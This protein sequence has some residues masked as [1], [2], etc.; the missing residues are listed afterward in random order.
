MVINNIRGIAFDLDGT[1]IDSLP[2]IALATSATLEHLGFQSCSLEQ[3]KTWIGNGA[4]ILISR[5]LKFASGREYSGQE[6]NQVMPIFLGFYQDFLTHSSCCFPK[7]TS[8]L[9]RLSQS[10]LKLGVITNK[11]HKFVAPLLNKL[12]IADYFSAVL[13]GDALVEMK[14]SPLPL[15]HVMQAW[16]LNANEFLMVGDSK[17]DISAAKAAN[18]ASIGLTY[19][20]NYGED[21]ALSYPTFVCDCF[22][23]IPSCLGLS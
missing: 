13:G 6:L 8:T 18:C 7:V 15:Q 10:G 3:V 19:G 17:N 22:S 14:P 12:Q 16:Q 20:Y 23:E 1:L 4:R 21:I 11:P 9:E 2:D 5:A